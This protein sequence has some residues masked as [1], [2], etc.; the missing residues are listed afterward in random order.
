MKFVLFEKLAEL[1]G[2]ELIM[3][4]CAAAAAIALCA[5][6][7][8][9]ARRDGRQKPGSSKISTK[10]LVQGALCVAL[11]FVLSYIKLFSMPMGGSITLFS[12]L[13]IFVYAWLYGPAAGFLAGFAY[14]LLQII[15]GAYVIHPVQFLLD[16]F[17]SF[18]LLGVAGFCKKSLALGALAGGLCRMLCGIISG[19]VFF[20]DAAAQ[21][22]YASIWGYTIIYN[23]STIG[24]DTALCVIAAL[25]PAVSK[26]AARIKSGK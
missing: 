9:R 17:F 14:S 20:A 26:T 22:G 19:A 24:A 25:I 4:L 10:M 5:L 1:E 18:T 12:M 16:Y 7:V 8:I 21:A 11:A 13:P 23:L 3:L 15:Q 2:T 6:L